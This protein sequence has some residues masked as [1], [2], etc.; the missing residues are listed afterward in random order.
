MGQQHRR[1]RETCS[2][3]D[4]NEAAVDDAYE[5]DI[6]KEHALTDSDSCL[7]ALFP[8]V[9]ILEDSVLGFLVEWTEL[10]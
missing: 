2:Q 10:V 7:P 8:P 4:C 1:A 5:E 9:A 6:G 3:Y